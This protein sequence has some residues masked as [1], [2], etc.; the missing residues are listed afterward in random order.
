[1]AGAE[2]RGLTGDRRDAYIYG[3]MRKLEMTSKKLKR[4]RSGRDYKILHRAKKGT[5]K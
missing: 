3:T 2:K 1:M 4:N 5:S